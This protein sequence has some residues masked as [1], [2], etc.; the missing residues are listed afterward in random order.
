MKPELAILVKLGSIAVHVEE[1]MSPDGHGADKISL[2]AL[3]DE[4]DLKAWIEQM[5]KI[6]LMPKKRNS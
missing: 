4:P 6:G 3:L 5:D 2:E 1:M